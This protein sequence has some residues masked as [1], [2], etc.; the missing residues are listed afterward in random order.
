MLRAYGQLHRGDIEGESLAREGLVVLSDTETKWGLPFLLVTFADLLHQYRPEQ[1][2]AL[3]Q[4]AFNAVDITEERWFQ[5]ELYRLR[6]HFALS[7]PSAEE[8]AER[9]FATAKRIAEQQ[10]SKLLELR[11]A[12]SLGRLCLGQGRRSEAC[13]LL[14]PVYNWFSEGL[15]LP[16]LKNAHALLNTPGQEG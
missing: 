2:I 3:V 5:A 9:D 11:A 10:G 4:E 1:S 14:A 15:R 7:D 12:L 16:D 13:D 8:R 6:G